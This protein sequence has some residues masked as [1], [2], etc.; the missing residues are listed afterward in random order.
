MRLLLLLPEQARG[1]CCRLQPW[2]RRHR[3]PPSPACSGARRGGRGAGSGEKG[4]RCG[5]GVPDVRAAA[6]ARG[7]PREAPA[8]H[9]ILRRAPGP[10]PGTP[11]RVVVP[12][13]QPAPRASARA[14]A[15]AAQQ[16]GSSSARGPLA[17]LPPPQPRAWLPPAARL[18]ARQPHGPPESL[19]L[20]ARRCALRPPAASLARR[21]PGGLCHE[22]LC[23]RPAA[24]AC[25]A[26][27][28]HTCTRQSRGAPRS[29]APA[30]CAAASSSPEPWG[31]VARPQQRRRGLP[32]TSA[33]CAS[34]AA[35]STSQ[36]PRTPC[37]C[38]AAAGEQRLQR[39]LQ[40][41]GPRGARRRRWRR[42]R[43]AAAASRRRP[44]RPP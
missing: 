38:G 27:E 3:Q 11:S 10:S 30:A 36:R 15:S 32:C 44:Q 18:G 9:C 31:L 19:R 22:Q 35:P 1:S 13:G 21:C 25:T 40:Q 6:S 17:R 34:T 42:G 33:R 29:S 4:W 16:H 28:I 2:Q 24:R 20:A 7:P 5:C 23:L 37:A 41:G 14:S 26:A 39:R 12:Q 43:A 8:A